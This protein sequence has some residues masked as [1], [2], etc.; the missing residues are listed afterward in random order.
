MKKIQLTHDVFAKV[1]EDDYARLSSFKWIINKS[2]L[3][4][5]GDGYAVR[6]TFGRKGKKI[7]MHREIISAPLGM[8]VDHI[9]GDGLDNRRSNLRVATRA[10]NGR[11]RKPQTGTSSVY[12]GVS[13][14]KQAQQ[15]RAYVK[16]DRKLIHIG[17]FHDEVEAA[18]AYDEAA[19]RLFG[20]DAKTNF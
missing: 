17:L 5:P 10:E 18:E 16:G 2:P 14:D 8:E 1:D 13:W 7:F 3:K 15:W 6:C 20:E 12:K 19:R 4:Y 9:N 11:N